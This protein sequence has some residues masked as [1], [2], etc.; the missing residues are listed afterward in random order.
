MSVPIDI[1][2]YVVA[3]TCPCG[4]E[5]RTVA[6]RNTVSGQRIASQTMDIVRLAVKWAREH[7]EHGEP[8]G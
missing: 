1:G 5:F 6:P 3:M 2:A 8:T 4:E 7:A